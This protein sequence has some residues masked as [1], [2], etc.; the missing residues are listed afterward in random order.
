MAIKI[1]VVTATY[2]SESTVSPTVESVIA[3]TYPHREYVV[4]D[5]ASKDT[6]LD[7]LSSYGEGIDVLHSAPDKGIYD[8]LN[9]GIAMSTGDVVGFMHSDDVFAY[10][11]ALADI[12]RVFEETGADAVYGDLCYVSQQDIDKVIRYWKSQPF[13]A[14]LLHRG[15]MPPHPTLY[16]KK[17]V[18]MR[19]GLYRLDFRIASDYELVLRYFGTHGIKTAY[20]PRTI[21]KM[22]MGGASNQPNLLL[23]KM[24]ED[25]RALKIN[26]IGGVSTLLWKNVSKFPQFLASGK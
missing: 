21:V 24:R 2:N 7:I 10:P 8:A 16:I 25:Y 26:Q 4:V 14:K 22:R 3:Q 13:S 20:L 5:G 17:E 12:A 11:E 15:W 18:Y 1:S 23:R 19:L 9:K 6:T